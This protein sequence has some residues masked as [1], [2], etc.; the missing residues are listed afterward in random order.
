MTKTS[1]K[2][3]C[4]ELLAKYPAGSIIYDTQDINFLITLFSK[5]PEAEEKQGIGI[6]T[7]LTIKNPQFNSTCFAIQRV[8]GTIVDISYHTCID[9]APT[10]LAEVKK[11]CRRAIQPIILDFRQ[12]VYFGH[13]TCEFTG[14]VLY[15]D[16]THIDHYDLT[17]K[18]LFN[19]WMTDK[20]IPDL[21]SKI[22]HEAIKTFSGETCFT[23]PTISADFISFHND[24][25]H[26][27]AVSA[28][29]NLSILR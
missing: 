19:E 10:P 29:A 20:S 12:T 21:H 1:L 3:M 28:T 14:E 7:I 22:N 16:N 27:R 8:D 2:R 9:G 26:L 18:D 24:N 5:H 23:D 11:A 4:R 6:R 25:T 13:D 15:P 17:F